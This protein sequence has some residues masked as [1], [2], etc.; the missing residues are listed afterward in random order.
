MEYNT[1]QYIIAML[2]A[3]KI[4][5]VVA[6]PGTRNSCFNY[7]VQED[8]FFECYSVLDERSAAYVATGLA[9]EKQ[10]PVVITCTGATASRNYLSAL[11]E[12]YYRK[13]PIIALTFLD[14]NTNRFNIMPQYIDRSVSQNDV[15]A[16]S[17]QL[18]EINSN[19]D[20]SRCLTYLNAA[21]SKAVYNNEPVHIDSVSNFEFDR[22]KK[23]LPSVWKTEYLNENFEI[24]PDELKNKNIAIFIGSHKKFTQAEE[25]NISKFAEKNGIPVFCDN[26][27][28]YYGKNKIMIAQIASMKRLNIFPDLIID[29]GEISGEYSF[30]SCFKKAKIWRISELCKFANRNNRPLEKLFCCS[31]LTFFKKLLD[32]NLEK[33]YYFNQ[34]AELLQ[35]IKILELPL[36]NSLISMELSKHLPK[37]SSLHIAILNSLRN[38][39][40]FE[41]DKSIYIN[42]NVGGFGIDGAVST[43]VGQSLANINKKCFGV[44]GD[45][46]FFYDMNILGNKHIKNNLRLIVVNNQKSVE[47]R[48]NSHTCQQNIQD[49]A[50]YLIA[51]AGHNKGG[52]KGWAESCGFRYMSA[53][54]KENFLEQIEEFCNCDCESPILFEVFTTTEDEQK[55]LDLMVNSNRNQIEEGLI[56]LYKGVKKII[57]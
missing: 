8:S 14:D 15:K 21:L 54:T 42:C 18:G 57:K 28:N 37:N 43:L 7:M 40:F 27:S 50:D 25:D 23:P 19:E 30:I 45:T 34:L 44:I 49:K 22:A 4:N 32:L 2:K 29:I 6:S 13:I 46:A 56:N 38:S 9:Y 35:D 51:A 55:G 41:F 24:S 48:L 26:T 53:N 5:T 31:E 1:L 11:T 20:I 39:N 10:K 16:L 36:C 33:S 17:V 47:F 12:A 3:Y 52:A